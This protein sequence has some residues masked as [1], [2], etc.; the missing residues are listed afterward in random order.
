MISTDTD[1]TLKGHGHKRE[2]VGEG[3]RSRHGLETDLDTEKKREK[4]GVRR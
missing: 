3:K 1:T 2:S 4:G